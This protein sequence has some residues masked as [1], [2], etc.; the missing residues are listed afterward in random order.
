MYQL[1]VQLIKLAIL[2]YFSQYWYASQYD[3]LGSLAMPAAISLKFVLG[4]GQS[5]S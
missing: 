3:L 4:T 2:P 1:R 5:I